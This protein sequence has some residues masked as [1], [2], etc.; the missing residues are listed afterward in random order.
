M[1][2]LFQICYHNA[3][4]DI[5]LS[6]GADRINR[7]MKGIIKK[8]DIILF[9]VL[10]ILGAILTVVP[11]LGDDNRTQVVITVEGKVYGTYPLSKNQTITIEEN[12]H[13]NVVA[14]KDDKIQMME[15]T[16]DN[17]IC[18]NQGAVGTGNLPIVCLPNRVTVVIVEE[19]EEQ[20]VV[21][22]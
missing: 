3:V 15:S 20:D 10:I 2:S 13:R 7:I 9:F 18:V 14:I 6:G 5:R 21:T 22:G 16:C 4:L 11:L 19:E 12:G 1:T 8:A 17:Q